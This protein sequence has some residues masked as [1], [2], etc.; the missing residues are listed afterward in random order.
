MWKASPEKAGDP[1]I[2]RV[3]SNLPGAGLIGKMGAGG[4]RESLDASP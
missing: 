2:R 3:F 4:R 1:V